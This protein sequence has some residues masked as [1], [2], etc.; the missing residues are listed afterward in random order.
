V[1]SPMQLGRI[2]LV[3]MLSLPSFGKVFPATADSVPAENRRAD[4]AHI[5]RYETEKDVQR[6]TRGGELL[7][8]P[9]CSPSL[10]KAR[11]TTGCYA[12]RD[13]VDFVRTL[14]EESPRGF[15]EAMQIDSATRSMQIQQAVRRVNKSAAPAYGSAPSSHERGT[16][17][18]ISR[19]SLSHSQRRWLITRLLY[20]RAIGRILVIEERA[21]YH[22][23]V[24]P[25]GMYVQKETDG[26]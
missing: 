5:K 6:A 23:F 11:P 13:T 12:R 2:L 10:K 22:I 26:R 16:T 3:L 4:E 17:V 1:V 19:Q 14:I 15:R 24:I 21:C 18:D 9:N 8:L 25:G 20:Y 7:L